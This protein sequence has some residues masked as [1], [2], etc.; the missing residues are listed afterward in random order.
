MEKGWENGLCRPGWDNYGRFPFTVISLAYSL[1]TKLSLLTCHTR[2]HDAKRFTIPISAQLGT[3]EEEKER[4]S[5][6]RVDIQ[7]RIM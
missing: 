4:K 5:S 6:H 2:G 7:L 3:G 1:G